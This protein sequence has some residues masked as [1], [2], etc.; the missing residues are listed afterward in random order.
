MEQNNTHNLPEAHEGSVLDILSLF[1]IPI[2]L[3]YNEMILKAF[4]G[5]PIFEG[6][7]LLLL[8]SLTAGFIISG[9]ISFL[10]PKAHKITGIIF[11]YL[12]AL[13][14]TTQC[15]IRNSFQ[16]YMEF[17]SIFAGLEGVVTGYSE[18]IFNSVINSVPNLLL[19]FAPP[20][21]YTVLGR[22]L[23]FVPEKKLRPV[24]SAA[25]TAL[26]FPPGI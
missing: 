3:V 18:N 26:A 25:V 7:G 13:L 21:I 6:C 14:F 23:H 5:Q 19:F 16:L 2:V 15:L 24:I 8:F 11:L 10:P 20:V 1:Y 22:K 9:L 4:A 12:S 17:D